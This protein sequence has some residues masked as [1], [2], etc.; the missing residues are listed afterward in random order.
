[1]KKGRKYGFLVLVLSKQQY[2]MVVGN[3]EVQWTTTKDPGGYNDTIQAKGT[4]RWVIEYEKFLGVEESL[5]TLILQV[6]EEP[7][8]KALKEEYIGYGGRTPFEMIAHLCIKINKVTN[9]DK[10]QPYCPCTS[11]KL[12]MQENNCKNGV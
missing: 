5:L 7:Y 2:G 3:G 9:K 12:K 10:V 6:V 8:L 4:A 11:S 1:M